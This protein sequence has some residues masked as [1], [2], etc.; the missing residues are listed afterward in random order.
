MNRDSEDMIDNR[1]RRHRLKSFRNIVI[2]FLIVAFCGY[3]YMQRDA[4]IPR[5]EGI[6]S[7]YHSVT[8][9]DGELAEGNFP[10]LFSG[11]S[12]YQAELVDDTLFFLHDA[13]LELYSLHGDH[14]DTR[15]HAYQNAMI[16]TSSKY[17]L[18]YESG[19]TSFRLDS[20]N[21]NIYNK[22]VDDDIITGKVSDNG[23]VVLITE[24]GSYACTIQV[25]DNTGKRIY[26][27]DCL[28]HV[29]D[30][31]FHKDEDG[32]FFTS[33]QVQN[34]VLQSTVTSVLFH[35]V[36]TQWTSLP[37]DTM[38]I[39][40][41]VSYDGSLCVIGDTSCTYFSDTGEVLSTFS[42]DASLLSEHYENGRVALILQ[43][44]QT[45]AT[46]LVLLDK[47]ASDLEKVPIEDTAELV[48][49]F[50]GDAIVMC[51]GKVTSYDFSG[52]ALA[53][54]SLEGAYTSFIKRDGYLFLMGYE[55]M[56]RV[57]F[58]E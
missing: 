43:D 40:T 57:D 23:N 53:T 29:V 13:Y 35:Q 25:Y 51:P 52:T 17:A 6:G 20:K 42:Y 24:S 41:G 32:C 31:S 45:R 4:W 5:L 14:K 8:E 22:S 50:E 18:L 38:A 47:S 54:V 33:I 11:S 49:V 56:D 58:K 2:F 21:K 37:M 27:R 1:K 10:L 39:T 46:T 3:L 30:V 16:S 12:G 15:Q 28:E 36:D 48:K 44:D 19:G 26:Q 9:N 55:Q 34:G 7:R